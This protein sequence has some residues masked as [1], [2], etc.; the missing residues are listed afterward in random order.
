MKQILYIIR[1][2]FLMTVNRKAYVVSVVVVPLII[3]LF[4]LVIK[5]SVSKYE[6]AMDRATIGIVDETKMIDFKLAD[7]AQQP[8]PENTDL[9]AD[10]RHYKL[11]RY[12]SVDAG[13]SD[14]KQGKLAALYVVAADYLQSGKVRVYIKESWRVTSGKSPGLENFQTLLR[15]SLLQS[16]VTSDTLNRVVQPAQLEELALGRDDSIAPV[17]GKWQKMNSFFAPFGLSFILII[18]I[19]ISTG[20]L[21]QST[22]EEKENRVIEVMLSTVT[23]DQ[24]LWGKVLGLAG[25]ALL[26]VVLYLILFSLSNSYGLIAA[27]LRPRILMLSLAFTIAGYLLF[28]GILVAIGIVG[29]KLRESSQV[30][31]VWTFIAMSPFWFLSILVDSPNGTIARILSYFPL[32]S[33]L[34]MI[35]RLSFTVVPTMDVVISLTLLVI[36]AYASVRAAAKIFRAASLLYGK[37]P[38][39]PEIFRWMREA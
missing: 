17:K 24:L 30:A 37:R 22:V 12:E 11:E 25:A 2:E 35:F 39:L 32:T 13:I 15:S 38:T 21:L 19:F 18:A 4:G 20:Y 28:A 5:Y 29:G 7:T 9:L 36:S 1:R 8:S 34:T 33:P 10:K 31:S 14:V 23:P 26:Q 27:D 16:K 3:L 6:S